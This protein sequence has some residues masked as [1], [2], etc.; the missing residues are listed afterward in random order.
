MVCLVLAVA[1]APA[2]AAPVLTVPPGVHG[3]ESGFA[4]YPSA[5][6]SI[7]AG[8][9]H[10]TRTDS[11]GRRRALRQ[12]DRLIRIGGGVGPR[13]E[14]QAAYDIA[15]SARWLVVALQRI[16]TLVDPNLPLASEG[17]TILQVARRTG[18]ARTLVRC[19]QGDTEPLALRGS[20]LAY[21]SCDGRSTLVRD[22]DRPS[23]VVRLPIRGDRAAFAGPRV[24]VFDAPAWTGGGSALGVFELAGGRRVVSA[25]D[26]YED[27]GG[28]PDGTVLLAPIRPDGA[29]CHRSPTRLLSPAA[30]DPRPLPGVCGTWLAGGHVLG[31]TEA[32]PLVGGSARPMR[33]NGWLVDAVHPDGSVRLVDER[34]EHVGARFTFA[35][36]GVLL[37]DGPRRPPT[38]PRRP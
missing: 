4:V 33:L 26:A 16:D 1:V 24:V 23:R 13:G 30:V 32:Q 27:F 17:R 29:P 38:C 21:R 37:G 22:L 36:A 12:F 19:E 14:E 2:S 11:R 35:R 9:P 7:E 31:S 3:T 10:L 5:M 15:A 25:T 18:R 6:Y 34:C 28:A 20:V 8:R